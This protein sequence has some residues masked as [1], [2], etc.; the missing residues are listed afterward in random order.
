M[1]TTYGTWDGIVERECVIEAGNDD[2]GFDSDFVGNE[3]MSLDA[4]RERVAE[5]RQAASRSDSDGETPTAEGGMNWFGWTFR[6]VML[7]AEN[8]YRLIVQEVI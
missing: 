1:K 5:L 8:C 7:D 3:P 4:A 6:I 2:N